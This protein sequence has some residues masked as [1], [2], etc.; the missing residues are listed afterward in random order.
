MAATRTAWTRRYTAFRIFCWLE[1]LEFGL[2]FLFLFLGLTLHVTFHLFVVRAFVGW[3]PR[4]RTPCNILFR[5]VD[6]FQRG[7]V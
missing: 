3:R 5:I 1:I 7:F 2:F 6:R 4:W